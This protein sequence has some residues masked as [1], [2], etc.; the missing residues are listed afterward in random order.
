MQSSLLLVYLSENT[1]E[2]RFRSYLATG[3]V[4]GISGYSRVS[5]PDQRPVP[6]LFNATMGPYGVEGVVNY[7]ILDTDYDN[8]SFVVDCAN[9]NATHSSESYWLYGRTTPLPKVARKRADKLAS[10]LLDVTKIYSVVQG[11]PECDLGW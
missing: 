3:K 8:Y 9:I 11:I 2:S 5:F 4:G 10:R 7:W 6:A 1:L